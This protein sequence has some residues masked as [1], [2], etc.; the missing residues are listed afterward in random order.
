MSDPTP[1]KLISAGITRGLI[2]AYSR[3][4]RPSQ[5]AAISAGITRGLIEAAASRRSFA[6]WQYDFRGD[7][8]RPH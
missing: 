2:E 4:S 6:Q 1:T 7:N 5:L 3:S 8:P